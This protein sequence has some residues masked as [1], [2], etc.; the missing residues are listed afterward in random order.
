MILSSVL[1][2][3]SS[4]EHDFIRIKYSFQ[5]S[6]GLGV[7]Q[8]ERFHTYRERAD[9]CGSW[10]GWYLAW[11][12]GVIVQVEGKSRSSGVS[13]LLTRSSMRW[14]LVCLLFGLW[15]FLIGL[16]ELEAQVRWGP[17][18][19]NVTDTGATVKVGIA[20]ED[21]A[22][23]VLYRDS[24]WKEEVDAV[25]AMPEYLFGDTAYT[26]QLRGLESGRR[27]FY[28][29]L[30]GGD[31]V[32]GSLRTFSDEVDGE[33]RIAFGSCIA[34]DSIFER[35]AQYDPDVTVILGDWG[36]YDVQPFDP[37]EPV[38]TS[39]DTLL[40]K[41]SWRRRLTMPVLRRYMAHHNMAYVWDDH[42]FTTT[43]AAR[44]SVPWYVVD[45]VRGTVEVRVVP[46][47]AHTV[48]NAMRAYRFYFPHYPLVFDGQSLMQVFS[49]AT[50]TVYLLDV[51]SNREVHV[52]AF[53]KVGGQWTFDS[54]VAITLLGD[55]VQRWLREALR[56]DARTWKPMFSSVVFNRKLRQL[57]TQLLALQ[58]IRPELAAVAMGMAD[59]WAGFAVEQEALLE[60]IERHDIF[61]VLIGTG[62]IH[63]S[64]MDDGANAGIPEIVAGN[65][66][67]ENSKLFYLLDSLTG[68]NASHYWNG[69]GQG[70]GNRNFRYAFG[71]LTFYGNDS[72]R[73]QLIDIDHHVIAE[74]VLYANRHVG[75]ENKIKI[76]KCTVFPNPTRD[77]LWIVGEKSWEYAELV[78]LHGRVI[79][80]E[81]HPMIDVRD[82]PAG[83]YL[84]KVYCGDGMTMRVVIVQ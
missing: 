10:I 7:H 73:M 27:Y 75:E 31:T 47:N 41:D 49:F 12:E 26:F 53:E 43:D 70:L 54:T 69:G 84:L 80:R 4:Q 13:L 74:Q 60:Y 64:G 32:V 29:I 21:A 65:L 18:V 6:C 56:E 36:Y 83:V 71:L 62:D 14:R 9:L 82:V 33:F 63:S 17:I 78:T 48:R 34:V 3:G 58:G 39:D 76:P 28:R 40:L 66:G 50:G 22:A 44:E 15:P 61:N 24:T 16:A 2:K 55:T 37:E 59:S 25:V 77:F 81:V 46:Y 11:G 72:C 52:R 38:Y 42:D 45:S 8:V 5:A 51:R 20:A 30:T 19:G 68:G 57:I 67:Q 23:L 35:I 1:R 79:A